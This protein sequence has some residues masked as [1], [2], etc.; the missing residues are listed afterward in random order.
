MS[1]LRKWGSALALVLVVIGSIGLLF[2]LAILV[3]VGFLPGEFI[4][5]R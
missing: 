3:H 5:A 2:L 1:A 4:R